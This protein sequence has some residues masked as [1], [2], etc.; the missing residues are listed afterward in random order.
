MSLLLKCVKKFLNFHFILPTFGVRFEIANGEVL[1][2]HVGVM[3]L[4]TS[5]VHA[6]QLYTYVPH[7][8]S[9][10]TNGE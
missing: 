7:Y 1:Q 5:F 4:K 2:L 8:T 9:C 3:F 6:S 10:R